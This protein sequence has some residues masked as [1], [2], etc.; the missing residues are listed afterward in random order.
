MQ[1]VAKATRKEKCLFLVCTAPSA[2]IA[3]TAG[4]VFHGLSYCNL[5]MK[6]LAS[7]KFYR[8]IVGKDDVGILCNFAYTADY[9]LNSRR[10]VNPR[11]LCTKLSIAK[12]G[13]SQGRD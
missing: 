6:S 4:L 3:T 7:K 2:K 13:A 11:G 8:K 1:C 9:F 5:A 10:F 12:H